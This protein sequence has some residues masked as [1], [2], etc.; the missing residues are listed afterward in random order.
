MSKDRLYIVE[1][2]EEDIF[3]NKN[4]KIKPGLIANKSLCYLIE[5][6]PENIQKFAMSFLL[7]EL[8][9]EEKSLAPDLTSRCKKCNKPILKIV[10]KRSGLC[11]KCQP[12]FQTNCYSSLPPPKGPLEEAA[13]TMLIKDIAKHY[14]VSY[15]VILNWFKK[16]NIKERK[17]S[18]EDRK[19]VPP[20]EILIEDLKIMNITEISEKYDV[21][22][23]IM[24]KWIRRY[25]LKKEKPSKEEFEVYYGKMTNK[26]LAEK[27]DVSEV[28]IRA[29]AK[30]FEMG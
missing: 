13:K 5:H 2:D 20:K 15:M 24:H 11:K 22:K 18:H 19:K 12:K 26:A 29:W 3:Y 14:G 10:K 23:P 7:N 21:S 16:Y 27:Y 17:F 1:K 30:K 4:R 8:A 6:Y 9:K 25:G 28:T